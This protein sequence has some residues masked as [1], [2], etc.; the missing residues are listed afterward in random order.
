MTEPRRHHRHWHTSALWLIVALAL[1]LPVQAGLWWLHGDLF[2]WANVAASTGIVCLFLASSWLLHHAPRLWAGLAALAVIVLIF[3]RLLFA[4]I[5]HFSGRGFDANLFINFNPEAMQVAWDQYRAWFLV[6]GL[7][8][9]AVVALFAWLGRR[10][11]APRA[12]LAAGLGILG[13]ILLASGHPASPGW[14]LYA[15]AHEWM[16]PK[17]IAL[18]SGRLD[19]WQ[20]SPLVHVDLVSKQNLWARPGQPPKNLILLY[21]ESGGLGF[22]DNPRQPG[23]M[24]TMH[25]LI[26]EHG[27]LPYIQASSYITVEGLTNSMCGTLLPFQH[28]SDTMAGFDNMV[29]QMPCLGDILHAA[30]YQQSYL[31]GSGKKFAGK[32]RFLAIH[33]YDKVMGLGDWRELGLDQRPGSWGLSDVD[34]FQ[35]SLE[36]LARLRASGKPFNLTMLTI[37]THIPGFAYEECTPYDNGNDSFLNA[38]HCTDQLIGRWLDELRQRGWLDANTI[39][40]ITGDHNFF[41]NPRMR[42]LFGDKATDQRRLPFVV[43]G[44]NLPQPVQQHGS[45][46]DIAPTL[47]DLL[48]VTTNARF[49]LGRSLLRD[50]HRLDYFPSRYIDTWN[51]QQ[52]N[53]DDPFDCNPANHARIP[54]KQPLSRC[55]RKELATI[56]RKQ[57]RL[58]SAPPVQMN[59]A[60][61]EPIAIHLPA[62]NDGKLAVMVSGSPQA[63]RFTWQ[64][65]HIEA[66]RKGLFFMALDGKGRLLR[67]EYAPVD[68]LDKKF[69][70]KPDLGNS[71]LLLIVWL[72]GDDTSDKAAHLPGWLVKA[73]ASDRPGAWLFGVKNQTL[74]LV[75]ASKAGDLQVTSTQCRSL[76]APPDSTE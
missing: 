15:A 70:D 40:A 29:D 5:V 18:A 34:L 1:F 53:F 39:V 59:C 35:Q 21:I 33:G 51:D 11:W 52:W 27:F 2:S 17:S 7:A 66:D 25:R 44:K 61:I 10:L 8:I 58:L 46:V 57:A 31:G 56:L 3:L 47:L 75:T 24:P 41:P 62:S 71:A 6:F 20:K 73:G 69:A 55:E 60:A 37:G 63:E 12:S 16:T 72:P 43:I 22:V 64:Q 48:G 13:I 38:V 19:V 67:R 23:L 30:G 45:G 32:G 28:G 74:A 50:K 49:A 9:I 4:G 76:L 68:Q 14:Q 42:H 26:E 65:R 36:E 54:G